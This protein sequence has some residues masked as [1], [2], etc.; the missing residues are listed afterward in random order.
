MNS[1]LLDNWFLES[2]YYDKND[3]RN[4]TVSTSYGNLLNAIVLWDTLFFPDNEYS[5]AWKQCF[6]ELN[7][8][9][10]AYEDKSNLFLQE[11]T[12]ITQ[13]ANFNESSVVCIGAIRY[14][15]LSNSLELDY[16]PVPQ[17]AAFISKYSNC[18]GEKFKALTRIDL[19]R[20]ID[21][22]VTEYYD[23]L[24]SIF[25]KNIF[26]I[27]MPILTDFIIQTCPKDMS[28]ISYA[29]NLRNDKAIKKYK[30]CMN[31]LD[32]AFN[33]GNWNEISAYIEAT[34]SI[35]KSIT[36]MD[37]NCVFNISLSLAVMPLLT[38]SVNLGKDF[39]LRRRKYVH[40]AFIKK[41]AK[42]SLQ[43]K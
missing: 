10:I 7:N 4:K 1:V 40:L 32:N 11:A 14:L 12:E 28:Y 3:Y 15:L 38:P 37:K 21:K 42:F 36:K 39:N 5:F 35:V 17:R 31:D 16:M 18:L 25:G 33:N 9:L 13:N 22:A 34:Y 24:N 20:V 27:S 19:S 43:K 26:T 8:I 6:P 41:L 30:K 29:I 2:T 23:E